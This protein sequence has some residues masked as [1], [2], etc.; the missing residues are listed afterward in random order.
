MRETAGYVIGHYRNDETRDASSFYVEGFL[1]APAWTCR[2]SANRYSNK[3]QAIREARAVAAVGYTT[4]VEPF[5]NPFPHA[6]P[7]TSVWTLR[8]DC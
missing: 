7:V 5:H 3:R 8:R 6:R 2:D 1:I 4:F